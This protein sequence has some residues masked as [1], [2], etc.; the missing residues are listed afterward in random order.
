MIVAFGLVLMLLWNWLIPEIFKGPQISFPQ[1]VGLL[2]MSEILFRGFGR[3][4][5]A[6]THFKREMWRSKCEQWKEK[7]GGP[8]EAAN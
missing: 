7:G 8:A 6:R 5:N 2:A 1:S 4:R 3:A